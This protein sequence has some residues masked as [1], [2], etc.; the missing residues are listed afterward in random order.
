MKNF[1]F[2]LILFTA[3]NYNNYDVNQK[4]FVNVIQD[5]NEFI[6]TQSE[7]L[8]EILE[9]IHSE[10]N[11]KDLNKIEFANFEQNFSKQN[12]NKLYQLANKGNDLFGVNGKFVSIPLV[13]KE[14]LIRDSRIK[15]LNLGTPCTDALDKD[16]AEAT[17]GYIGCMAGTGGSAIVSC[18]VAYAALIVVAEVTYSNCM[19]QYE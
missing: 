4:E 16:Y 13:E 12:L 5:K 1:L 6:K 9:L 14:E 3:C 10:R 15:I 8:Q 7:F 11:L 17:I 19:K 18:T 2:L